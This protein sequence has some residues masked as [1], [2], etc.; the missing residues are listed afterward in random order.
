[1]RACTDEVRKTRLLNHFNSTRRTH[2][3]HHLVLAELDHALVVLVQRE[4]DFRDRQAE[5]VLLIGTRRKLHA[6]LFPWQNLTQAVQMQ[7]SGYSP[8][9]CAVIA[10]PHSPFRSHHLLSQTQWAAGPPSGSAN[11]RAKSRLRIRLVK[12][13]RQCMRRAALYTCE[14]GRR[15]DPRSRYQPAPSGICQAYRLLFAS[16]FSWPGHAEFKQ[17]PGSLDRVSA[18]DHDASRAGSVRLPSRSK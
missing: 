15:S 3:L 14:S 2:D 16:P 18:D 7:T 11:P 5:A 6:I 1:M 8:S 17:Q 10:Q 9:R 13:F 4:R 12:L